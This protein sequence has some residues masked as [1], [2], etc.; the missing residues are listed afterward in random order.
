MPYVKSTRDYTEYTAITAVRRSLKIN[1]AVTAIT[2]V[3]ISP[4]IMDLHG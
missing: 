4:K 2:T 1:I 3:R